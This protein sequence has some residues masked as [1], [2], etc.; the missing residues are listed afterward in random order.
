MFTPPRRAHQPVAQISKRWIVL[1][2]AA[3]CHPRSF[4]VLFLCL[5]TA[6]ARKAGWGYGKK[7]YASPAR[8][9][10]AIPATNGPNLHAGT[11]PNGASGRDGLSEAGKGAIDAG[12]NLDLH[13]PGFAHAAISFAGSARLVGTEG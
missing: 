6:L 1:L 3:L 7:A 9:A 5:T 8:V 11:G 10:R 2:H 13:P 12:A 4:R